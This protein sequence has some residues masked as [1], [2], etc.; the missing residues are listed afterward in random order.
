M[1][2]NKTGSYSV[3]E[4]NKKYPDAYKKWTQEEDK[5]LIRAY[6]NGETINNLAKLF[7]RQSGGIRSRLKKLNEI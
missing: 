4:V 7:G 3:E 6:N 2:K 1:I 5:M